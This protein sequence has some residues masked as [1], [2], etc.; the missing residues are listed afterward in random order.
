MHK[1]ETDYHDYADQYKEELT[2]AING[3]GDK[4]ADPF[5]ITEKVLINHGVHDIKDEFWVYAAYR[6]TRDVIGKILAK[7]Q[8]PSQD[9]GA[10]QLEMYP[11]LQPRYAVKRDSRVVYVAR[12]RMTYLERRLESKKLRS[13]A[14]AKLAHA[15]QMDRETDALVASGALVP[16]AEAV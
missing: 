5:L 15:E 12:H 16:E 10:D 4:D 2:E 14:E 7:M 8:K 13:E 3:L 11:L 6:S 1:N 9:G